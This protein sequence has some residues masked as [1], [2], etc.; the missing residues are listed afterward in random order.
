MGARASPGRGRRPNDEQA[1]GPFL[2]P[3]EQALPDAAA[4]VAHACGS[5]YAALVRKVLGAKACAKEREKTFEGFGRAIAAWERSSRE[6]AALHRLRLRQRR[7]A[8]EPAKAYGHNGALKSL[9]EVVHFYNARDVERGRWAPP[10]YSPTVNTK[11]LGNLGLGAED[12]ADLVAFL[13]TLSDGFLRP[14]CGPARG[15]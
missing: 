6:A 12:E 15:R 5:D 1:L 7:P 10:E 9:E 8:A 4:V 14:A 3:A 13:R 11:E 2:H